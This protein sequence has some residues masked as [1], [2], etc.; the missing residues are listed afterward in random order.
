MK[1]DICKQ[2][3]SGFVVLIMLVMTSTIGAAGTGISPSGDSKENVSVPYE[4][5]LQT[6]A[7][8]PSFG[9]VFQL[10][11]DIPGMQFNIN[12]DMAGN[13]IV[14]GSISG[15]I[16]DPGKWLLTNGIITKSKLVFTAIYTGSGS[17]ANNVLFDTNRSEKRKFSGTY[18]WNYNT[19]PTAYNGVLTFVNFIPKTLNPDVPV[20]FEE[21]I[22][23]R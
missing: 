19:N 17:C 20:D 13:R 6:S 16:C 22:E 18:T 9:L 12:M 5:P 10:T 14:G 1:Y 3:M 11:N 21:L 7:I 2:I 8:P 15:D 23:R 4:H